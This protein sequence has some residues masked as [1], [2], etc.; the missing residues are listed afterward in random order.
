MTQIAEPQC[1]ARNCVHFT[2]SREGTGD[3][4]IVTCKAFPGGIPDEIA[5]GNNPHTTPFEGDGGTV[6]KQAKDRPIE[7]ET[8]E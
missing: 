4:I 7:E 2:G 3:E 8:Q 1:F 5:Y 6:F